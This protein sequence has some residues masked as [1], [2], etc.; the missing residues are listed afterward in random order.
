MSRQE[1][2]NP[3][4]HLILPLHNLRCSSDAQVIERV[5][6]R[7]PGVAEVYAN[8]VTER[9]HILYDAARTQPDQLRVVL[10]RSGFGSNTLHATRAHSR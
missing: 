10:R 3:L 4:Q 5:L 2:A 7:Q 9:V 1:H 8:P 6:G